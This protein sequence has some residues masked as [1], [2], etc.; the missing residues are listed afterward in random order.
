[1]SQP[2]VLFF[3]SDQ[4]R[5]DTCGCY[6]QPLPI[7]PHLDQMA[8]EGVLFE[9][10]YTCQPV[11]GPARAT[12]QTGQ[13]PTAVECPTNHC[14]PP[15]DSFAL[16]PAFKQAGYETGY[17]GKWHLASF[18]P[19]DGADDFRTKPVP[20]ER[21]GGY[22]YWLASDTLEFTSHSYDGHMFDG[23]EKQVDF[24]E[25]RYRVDA[26]T[27]WVL[28]YLRTR[29]IATGVTD[30]K[31]FFLMTSYIEPHH[32]NDHN[33]YEGPRGS[34]EQWANYDVPGDLVGT[35]GDWQENYPDYLGCCNSLDENLGRIFHT[36]TELGLADNTIVLYTSDHGSHFCT[37]NAEYKRSCHD[38]C[39]HI[40][41]LAW[42]GPFARGGQRVEELVSLIDIPPTLLASAGVAVPEQFAGRTLTDVLDGAP[43]DWPE[44]QLIQISE[45]QC[46]RAIRTERWTYSVY[47]P[48]Q[49]GHALNGQRYVEQYLY[50]NHTDPHQKNNLIQDPALAEVRADLRA[51]LTKCIQNAEGTE[52]EVVA[53][54]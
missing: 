51:R 45:S 52:P 13:W 41:M 39:T 47:D 29:D 11:C 49:P 14:M 10:A 48:D 38:G 20:P 26:Q 16:A 28:D 44:E 1:M 42:G 6:G 32:Q 18:G 25:G 54:C 37:R 24:P 35:E 40:P 33:C 3:F 4:Q 5:W 19:S 12:L 21:R 9:S 2:N 22:D 50:D 15:A 46:G 30:A 23:D 17:I 31:P 27:D 53:G 43:A 34:K 36:L 8:A 7:T